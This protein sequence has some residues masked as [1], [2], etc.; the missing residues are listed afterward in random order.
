MNNSVI[1]INLI[2]KDP[3]MVFYK[4]FVFALFFLTF[5]KC[6]DH[7]YG[8]ENGGNKELFSKV[9]LDHHT[10]Y[11]KNYTLIFKYIGSEWSPNITYAKFE[12]K[13]SVSCY[14]FFFH[15]ILYSFIQLFILTEK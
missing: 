5:C 14:I 15:K 1:I 7:V 3:I 8:I 11:P 10:P 9:L 13:N 12:V 4:I 2:E 6:D